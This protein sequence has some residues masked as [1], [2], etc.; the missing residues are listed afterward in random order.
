MLDDRTKKGIRILKTADDFF[1]FLPEEDRP[2]T[3]GVKKVQKASELKILQP[4]FLNNQTKLYFNK[5][6]E[7]NV[8]K[9]SIS[10]I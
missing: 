6:H 1:D 4:Y 9:Y 5:D 10:D 7:D 3:M 8:F 2:C